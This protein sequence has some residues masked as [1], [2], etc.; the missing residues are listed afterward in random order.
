MNTFFDYSR[1]AARILKE[2][3]V[4]LDEGVNRSIYKLGKRFA[5]K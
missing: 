4:S 2:L 3:Y 5:P 1:P